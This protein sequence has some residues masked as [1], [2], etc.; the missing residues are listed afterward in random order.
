MQSVHEEPGLKVM[1]SPDTEEL[2]S[3]KLR[4]ATPPKFWDFDTLLH[5][6]QATVQHADHTHWYLIVTVAS[7][8]STLLVLLYCYARTVQSLAP[9]QPPTK[10][11]KGV[12]LSTTNLALHN[13]CNGKH[14]FKHG[15]RHQHSTRCHVCE[16]C[17]ATRTVRKRNNQLATETPFQASI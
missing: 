15:R 8:T 6:Q 5:I 14:S 9:V 16:I 10:E 4:V 3:M 17:V 13:S 11:L 12:E 7:C 2:D 1:T